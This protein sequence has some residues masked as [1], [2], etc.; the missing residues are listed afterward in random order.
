MIK[1]A[2]VTSVLSFALLWSASLAHADSENGACENLAQAV[3]VQASDEQSLGAFAF[4]TQINPE[5]LKNYIQFLNGEKPL[6]G[7]F[8]L[9]NRNTSTNREVVRWAITHTLSQMGYRPEY[10]PFDKGANIILEITGT[11]NPREVIEFGAHYDTVEKGADDNGAGLALVIH[12]AELMKANPPGRTVRFVFYDLEEEGG[13]GS[14]HHAKQLKKQQAH[15]PR[16]F[17]GALVVDSIGYYPQN[18]SPKVLTAEIGKAANR[19]PMARE[20][21]YQLR[22]IAVDR[23]LLVSAETE[24]VDGE[25][26][27]H[28][29]YWNEDL[30]AILIARPYDEKFDSPFNH[31]TRDTTANMIWD[32]YTAAAKVYAELAGYT[33]RVKVDPELVSKLQIGALENLQFTLATD[34]QELPGSL[35]STIEKVARPPKPAKV[36]AKKE[37]KA[38][39]D[40]EAGKK[41]D[42]R[43]PPGEVPREEAQLTD[44]PHQFP[45]PEFEKAKAEERRSGGAWGWIK[46]IFKWPFGGDA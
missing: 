40:S 9:A 26:A 34:G 18:M 11:T 30:P 36:K 44:K 21:F 39:A 24:N 10:E 22:R 19:Q 17:L 3:A 6:W 38:K 4:A 42:D 33:A 16:Q 23:G 20:L 13:L 5:K 8:E 1:K 12:L 41:K 25:I 32:Y 28:G 14:A 15:D 46:D 31:G 37:P 27:D 2:I 43:S 45:A 7:G 35:L 29:S